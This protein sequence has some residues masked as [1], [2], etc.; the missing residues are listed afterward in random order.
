MSQ[1]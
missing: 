1:P